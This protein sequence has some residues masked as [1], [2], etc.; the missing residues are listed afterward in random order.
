MFGAIE[1]AEELHQPVVGAVMHH[2]K[3]IIR[4]TVPSDL[5]AVIADPLPCRIRT[6]TAVL[7]PSADGG[8]EETVLGVGGIAFLPGGVEAF[9]QAAPDAH[10]FPVAF[11]RAGL[12][13]MKMI[14]GSG[15]REVAASC[16][17]DNPPAVRWLK[18]LGFV[19][20]E[21]QPWPEKILWFWTRPRD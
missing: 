3:V 1:S 21:R 4:P 13:A 10:S 5:P 2:R 15:V 17:A 8:G 6:L 14:R 19:E 20:S 11:H 9:V 7:Q 12:M 18:R 16:D